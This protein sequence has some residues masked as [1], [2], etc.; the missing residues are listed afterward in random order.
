MTSRELLRRLRRLGAEVVTGRG[1]GGHVMVKLGNRRAIV[2]TGS[3][4]IPPGTFA[5]ILKQLG[6]RREQL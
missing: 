1:K 4:E 5:A 6:L 2:A 3:G